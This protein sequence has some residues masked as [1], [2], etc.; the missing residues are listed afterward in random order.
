MLCGDLNGKKIQK[1][2]DICIC[3]ADS[4]CCT[5]ETNTA[6]LSNYTPIKINLKKRN[7]CIHN[8]IVQIRH[9]AY[10]T[11]QHEF[12]VCVLTVCGFRLLQHNKNLVIFCK[13]NQ[14]NIDTL[15]IFQDAVILCVCCCYCC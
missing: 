1:R 7:M 2:G 12:C 8:I 14:Q 4:L 11:V 13:T 3:I 6:L 9:H 15:K 10:L 5:A